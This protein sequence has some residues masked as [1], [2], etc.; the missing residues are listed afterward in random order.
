MKKM[1]AVHWLLVVAALA[2]LPAVA[3][4]ETLTHPEGFTIEVPSGWSST[5]NLPSR[6]PWVGNKWLIRG[7]P[8]AGSG[9]L[10]QITIFFS[11]KPMDVATGQKE[12]AAMLGQ[13]TDG[14]KWEK[15]IAGKLG[16]AD[17]K[18]AF[19]QASYKKPAYP[20]HLEVHVFTTKSGKSITLLYA[21]PKDSKT[22]WR[23]TT[24]HKLNKS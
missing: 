9:K 22:D 8:E 20:I 4:A 14:L 7:E 17:T 11:A 1:S 12:L 6:D 10:V 13:N 2:L 3:M 5:T 15:E 23:L 18:A 24:I 21:Q 16:N 19:G